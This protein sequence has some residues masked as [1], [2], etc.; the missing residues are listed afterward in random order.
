MVKPSPVP[1]I[2][3]FVREGGGD[4]VKR[5]EGGQY[6]KGVPKGLILKISSRS[7]LIIQGYVSAPLHPTIVSSAHHVY[8]GVVPIYLY[9]IYSGV[10]PGVHYI[11]GVVPGEHYIYME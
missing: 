9:I 8:S 11:C 4:G 1:R 2:N 7:D 6:K 3:L 10:V 5:G